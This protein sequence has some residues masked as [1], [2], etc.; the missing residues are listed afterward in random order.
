MANCDEK[1]AHALNILKKSKG[2]SWEP[3]EEALKEIL[4]SQEVKD[5]KVSKTQNRCSVFLKSQN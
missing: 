4:M 3:D 1:K 5:K 2:T